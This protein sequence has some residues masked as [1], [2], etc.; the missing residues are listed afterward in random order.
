MSYY[1]T[2]GVLG[3]KYGQVGYYVI[4]P[5]AFGEGVM[6][7]GKAFAWIYGIFIGIFAGLFFRFLRRHDYL[8]YVYVYFFI[9]FGFAFRGGIQ[10]FVMRSL[11]CL[12]YF[13]I[14]MAL[15]RGLS[16]SQKTAFREFGTRENVS[17]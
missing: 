2:T 7:L 13:L 5:G 4:L 10:A 15:I 1:F 9:Q 16:R 14:V 3:L 6:V 11:N 17:N 12:V 8:R